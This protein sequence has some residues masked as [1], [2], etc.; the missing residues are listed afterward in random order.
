MNAVEAEDVHFS[1]GAEDAL[2]G[3]TFGAEDGEFVAVMGPNGSG[4]STLMK[5]ILG[6]LKPTRGKISVF[7]VDPGT[8]RER[9]QQYIGYMPQRENI[10]KKFP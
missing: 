2:S 7:G 8:E 4:K 6:L 9:A 1:Y 5:L 10:A 3:I